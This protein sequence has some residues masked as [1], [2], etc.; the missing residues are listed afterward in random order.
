MAAFVHP[1]LKQAFITPKPVTQNQTLTGT[2]SGKAFVNTNAT[3]AV[4]L[5]LPKAS[6]G[7]SVVTSGLTFQFLVA[8]AHNII[9]TPK[10]G[11]TIRGLAVSASLT[12]NT[13]GQLVQLECITAGF[14]EVLFDTT[15]GPLNVL[16]PPTTT[17]ASITTNTTVTVPNS[18]ANVF[19]ERTTTYTGGILGFVTPALEVVTNAG[20]NDAND[21]WSGL[22]IMNNSSLAT[23][24]SENVALYAQG[25]RLTNSVGPTWAAVF[26]VRDYSGAANP[27][28]GLVGIEIDVDCNGTD[29]SGA[30]NRV[31]CDLVIRQYNTGGA[32]AQANWGYRIQNNGVSGNNVGFGFAFA[33]GM[34][35]NVGFDTSHGTMNSAA[36]QLA[37]GQSIIFDGPTNLLN[38][39]EFDG[40]NL[41]YLSSGATVCSLLAAGGYYMSNGTHGVTVTPAVNTG[42][43]APALT[44]NKPGTLGTILTW[45]PCKVDGTNGWIAVWNN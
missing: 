14:W 12:L 21:E 5:T 29:S 13:V 11:D 35:A 7:L 6:V 31:G 26:E 20:A 45:I 33:P 27:T 38:K 8:A 19:I 28:V 3:T 2:D 41:S 43:Q 37:T 44:A 24:G 40:T 39:L 17:V 1:L 25:N 32:F 10:V 34:I 22:F 18:V 4:T 23:T 16:A 36:Y 9:I 30:G 15:S 42:T